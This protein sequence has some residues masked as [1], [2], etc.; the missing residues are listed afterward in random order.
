[1]SAFEDKVQMLSFD[2]NARVGPRIFLEPMP[3][4]QVW[5]KPQGVAHH[6]GLSQP[7]QL[8]LVGKP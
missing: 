1:M 7:V 4:D 3:A 6:P 2:N 8:T 5:P